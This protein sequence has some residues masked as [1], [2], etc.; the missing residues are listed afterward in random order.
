MKSDK[1]TRLRRIIKIFAVGAAGAVVL[2]WLRPPCLIYKVFGVYCPACGTQ[3]MLLSLLRGNVTEV[4]GYNPFM[5]V[6]LPLAAVY[7]LC[8]SLRYI[9]E[10]PLLYHSKGF[11]CIAIS[12]AVLALVFAVLRNLPS[13]AFLAP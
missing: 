11:S 10:K 13:L 5:F 3:R 6:L 8:E 9:K 7:F 1:N 4:I 12:V 2:L